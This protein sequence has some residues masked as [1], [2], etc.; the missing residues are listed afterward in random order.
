MTLRNNETFFNIRRVDA[1]FLVSKNYTLERNFLIDLVYILSEV[2][3]ITVLER[4]RR[5]YS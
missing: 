5:V 4:L 3:Y 2:F 1:V